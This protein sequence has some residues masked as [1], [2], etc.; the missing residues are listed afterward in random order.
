[1]EQK[2]RHR[3]FAF[4]AAFRQSSLHALTLSFSVAKQGKSVNYG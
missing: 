4:F 1:M 2:A 3:I